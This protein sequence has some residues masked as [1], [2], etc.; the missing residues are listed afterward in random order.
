VVASTVERRVEGL[1]SRCHAGLDAADLT[2]ELLRRLPGLVPVE[3][4][5]FAAVDP[6][7]LLFTSVVAQ[8]PLA[9][10]TPLFMDNEFGREDV[11]KFTALAAAPDPVRTLDQAT[12]GDRETSPRYREI[13]AGLGLGDELR[14]ALRTDGECWGVLCLHLADAESGFSSRDL[15]VVRHIAPHL[16]TAL[17]QAAVGNAVPAD[18]AGLSDV[19]AEAP[20]LAYVQDEPDESPDLPGVLILD[21]DLAVVSTTPAADHWLDQIAGPRTHKLPIPVYA[22][23]ARLA[24]T[25]GTNGTADHPATVR[26]HTPA[27]QWLAIHATPLRT[28]A[29]AQ[30]A[31][32]IEPAT[33]TEL[34]SLLLTAHG[35]TPAQTRVVALV[36]RGFS[37]HEIVNQ[38]HISA[39]TVQEHLT[40]VF[41]RFGVRSRRELI[42]GLLDSGRH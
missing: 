35:L 31:I 14:A 17:R 20:D 2:A 7:T 13:M 33:P 40:A 22:A 15:S 3:A 8:E 6:A 39:N 10:A 28:P 16:A 18:P 9:D 11:N 21:S 29:D 1:I 42:A 4:A 37:T 30:I 24:T 26:L 19:P 25:A 41:S 34:R 5:F 38:L 36:L 32:I 27:G 12:R 23:A